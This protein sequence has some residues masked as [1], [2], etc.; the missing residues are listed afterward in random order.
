[1]MM[2]SMPKRVFETPTQ[3]E[4]PDSTPA[5]GPLPAELDGLLLEGS[6][7]DLLPDPGLG[8]V[9]GDVEVYDPT[10]A[11]FHGDENVEGG[12][13]DGVLD[14]EVAGPDGARLVLEERPPTLRGRRGPD[15]FTMYLRM[16][17]S[18]CV[19]PNLISSS[20]AMRSSP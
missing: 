3:R 10:S 13:P 15:A 4:R 11:Q 5:G 8:R 20:R 9:F 17:A 6:V 12:E 19:M 2:G 18:E 16:V 14:A 1:M 7:A